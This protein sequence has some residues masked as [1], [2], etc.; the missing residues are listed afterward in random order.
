MQ[1]SIS[2]RLRALA[3]KTEPPPPHAKSCRGHRREGHHFSHTGK[4]T[5]AGARLKREWRSTIVPIDVERTAVR[6]ST[7]LHSRAFEGFWGGDEVAQVDG[8]LLIEKGEQATCMKGGEH[9]DRL[10]GRF[11][12]HPMPT[13]CA[14]RSPDGTPTLCSAR[15]RADKS[16]SLGL[17]T[18]SATEDKGVVIDHD[19]P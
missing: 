3:D 6:E 7:D 19:D 16:R 18:Q 15:P 8:Q 4:V 13:R 12:L 5:D 11:N 1:L 10:R 14:C 17:R 9:S 2:I